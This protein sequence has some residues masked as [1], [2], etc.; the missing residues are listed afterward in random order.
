VSSIDADSEQAAAR[1][2][3]LR[4]L[5]S[6]RHL[7]PVTQTRRLHGLLARRGYPPSVVARVV[8]GALTGADPAGDD[9]DGDDLDGPLDPD[10]YR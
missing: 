3:V 9:A 6:L 1:A 8:A 5:P 7:G 10:I 4:K 2:L